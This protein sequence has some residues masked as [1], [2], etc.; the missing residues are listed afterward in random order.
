MAEA[1]LSLSRSDQA[2]ALGVAADRSGRPVHLLQ[3]DVW[4]VWAL[5][6]L[7]AAPFGPHLVFKGGTSLSKAYQ[8]IARFSEDVDLTYDIRMSSSV[9]K[10]ATVRTWITPQLFVVRFILRQKGLGW[11]HSLTTM[12]ECSTMASL[13][14]H[15]P[16]LDHSSSTAKESNNAPIR[17]SH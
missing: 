13:S 17:I 6:T 11:Q 5:E 16:H 15:L 12:R 4:V 9:K 10:A 8:A 3:K 2:D 14:R 1:F 7:F